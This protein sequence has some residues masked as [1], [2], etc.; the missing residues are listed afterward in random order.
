MLQGS[1]EEVGGCGIRSNPALPAQ[2]SV[3][4]V[5]QDYLLEGSV[6]FA[7]TL[8]QVN[9][10][11]E[12]D[13]AVVVAMDQQDRRLPPADVG[14]GRGCPGEFDGSLFIGRLQSHVAEDR[15]L[16]EKDAPVVDSVEV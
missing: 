15:I 10:L 1:I 3:D 16:G 2:E 8:H 5:G 13:V 6:L 11:A 14:V 4:F 9:R 12:G 7:Q